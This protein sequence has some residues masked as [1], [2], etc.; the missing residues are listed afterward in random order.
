MTASPKIGGHCCSAV[1]LLFRPYM[2]EIFSLMFAGRLNNLFHIIPCA[3]H[4]VPC[5]FIQYNCFIDRYIEHNAK[6]TEHHNLIPIIFPKLKF[7]TTFPKT[8]VPISFSS[9]LVPPVSL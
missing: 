7:N 6:I 1:L 9:I 8:K 2:N 3:F 4:L 5:R